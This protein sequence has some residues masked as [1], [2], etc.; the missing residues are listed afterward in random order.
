MFFTPCAQPFPECFPV[1]VDRVW[2]S[3]V[4]LWPVAVYSLR[5]KVVSNTDVTC[6]V[7]GSEPEWSALTHGLINIPAAILYPP[8]W[9]CWLDGLCQTQW[10]FR[11]ITISFLPEFSCGTKLLPRW[12]CAKGQKSVSVCVCVRRSEWGHAHPRAQSS[13]PIYPRHSY[14][15]VSVHDRSLALHML[16][17]A[18]CELALQTAMVF[19]VHTHATCVH[20]HACGFGKIDYKNVPYRGSTFP[21][22]HSFPHCY[23]R[24]RLGIDW[25]GFDRNV[26]VR[27]FVLMWL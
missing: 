7:C 15:A 5:Q 24:V 10:G 3:C 27:G 16:R 23:S 8:L 25:G 20:A 2:R 1:W 19:H 13:I 12:D 26:C 17:R 22:F 9:G 18:R 6:S 4:L 11:C 21:M 14:I